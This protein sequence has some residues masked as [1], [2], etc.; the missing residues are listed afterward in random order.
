MSK[1]S[2]V[3]HRPVCRRPISRRGFNLVE[4]LI[5]LAISA[6]LLTA[7]MVALDASFTAYQMTTEVASTHTIGRLTIE[8]MQAL[9]RTGTDFGPFPVNPRDSIVV[10]DYIEFRTPGTTVNPQGQIMTLEWREDDQA[11]FVIVTDPDTG[12]D[13]EHLLLEGVVPQYDEDEQLIHPFT[14]EYELGRS[15]YR[16]TIDMTIIPDDNMSLEI[17]GDNQQ[18]IRLVASAMPRTAAYR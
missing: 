6:A 9:I 5:A 15:L 1:P 7:T 3:L 10:S 16:A 8:R 17:E 18:P 4:L 2:H 12:V 14:L 13:E 11:L